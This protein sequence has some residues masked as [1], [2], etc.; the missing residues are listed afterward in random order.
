MVVTVLA[1]LQRVYKIVQA[2]TYLTVNTLACADNQSAMHRH[3]D[4]SI[5]LGH[6]NICL[7]TENPSRWR[8]FSAWAPEMSRGNFTHEPG[9]GR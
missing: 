2:D 3:R 8:A 1:A 4:T 7:V 6:S 9:L 5:P